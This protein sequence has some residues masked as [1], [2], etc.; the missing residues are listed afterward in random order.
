MLFWT[1]VKVALKS[2]M[3]NKLRSF[4]AM[5]GIIIGVSAVIS[6]LSLG[7]GAQHQ[8]MDRFSE[9]GSN[10]LIAH[11]SRRRHR[12]VMAGEYQ[13]LTLEDAQAILAEVDSV[14]QVAPVVR[15][16]EQIKYF[17][18]NTRA[19]VLGSSIT[20]F[21]I[22]NFEVEKG[23]TFT[24]VEA[25]RMARVA[26]I[27][28]ETAKNLFDEGEDPVNKII[29]VKNINFKVVGVLKS[30]GGQ[31][32]FNPDEQIIMPYTTAMKQ[33]LG[34][35]HLREIDMQVVQG[36]DQSKAE[37]E[38]TVVLRR[39]HRIEPGAED[40]FDIFNQ[41]ELIET[42]TEVTQTFT[43]LLGSIAGISMLVGGIG[44]MNIM[45][46]TVTERTR[47]I[48]VRKA[49]GAKDRD[50]LSQFLIE[51]VLMSGLGGV[52]GVIAGV[53]GAKIVENAMDFA[54]VVEPSSILMA[55]SFSA[56]VGIFFGFYPAR[57]AAKLDP[58]E[59]LRY[60]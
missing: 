35:D 25:E 3:A 5:L 12:G 39:R 38:I 8:V 51:A 32:W 31:G 53:G 50:I 17:N 54:T 56:A 57:R 43:I 15:G 19:T 22:R 2:L 42:V 34:T 1:I 29:K 37:E 9:M 55:L 20:Y 16:N 52:I 10:L 7:A 6:M 33:V 13:N 46:V 48:G 21:P 18:K 23:R 4:L 36:Y 40:D 28:S 45:L 47:E 14:R 24:E 30:K 27:G 44:I 41:A 58:I 59:A 60:E 26:V 49:I 11:P